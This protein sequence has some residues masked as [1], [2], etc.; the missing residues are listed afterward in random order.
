VQVKQCLNEA[1]AD[2]LL[3]YVQKDNGSRHFQRFVFNIAE[4]ELE[5]A[6]RAFASLKD[7]PEKNMYVLTQANVVREAYKWW[8]R[9]L[10][11]YPPPQCISIIIAFMLESG[12]F[13]LKGEFLSK[14][15]MNLQSA[16]HLFRI[17][18]DPTT[19]TAET[20]R[21]IVFKP[22]NGTGGYADR[23]LGT[24]PDPMYPENITYTQ[25]VSRAEHLRDP[26][27][28]QIDNEPTIPMPTFHADSAAALHIQTGTD[29]API[30]PAIPIGLF[31]FLYTPANNSSDDES[32][33]ELPDAAADGTDYSQREGA[34]SARLSTQ[35]VRLLQR[36]TE[37]S[38]N[39]S[40]HTTL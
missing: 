10:Y 30:T 15:Q 1:H 3:G 7:D 17:M 38:H 11:P 35:T 21:S 16:N 2:H 39:T 31:P 27:L 37:W 9:Y 8:R 13:I 12:L 6:R 14:Y 29:G 34:E 24:P 28:Q 19:A 18:V 23:S 36:R 5:A 32:D 40:T 22:T 26:T 33:I 25:A 20:V 4:E